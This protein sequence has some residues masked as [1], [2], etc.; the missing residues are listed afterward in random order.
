M[1]SAGSALSIAQ[2]ISAKETEKQA[3]NLLVKIALRRLDYMKA[4]EYHARL[5]AVKDSLLNEASIKSLQELTAKY[6]SERKESKIALLEKDKLL[7]ELERTK[8]ADK[9]RAGA[10]EADRNRRKAQY[11]AAERALQSLALAKREAELR[12]RTADGESRRREAEIW[13]NNSALNKELLENQYDLQRALLAILVL[14]A[15][16]SVFAYRRQRA[17]RREERLRAES[18]EYKE[19]VAR[20]EA[21]QHEHRIQTEFSRQLLQTQERERSRLAGELH[22]SLGQQLVV[23]RNRALMG[24]EALEDKDRTKHQLKQISEMSM[25][26]LGSVR[27]ISHALRPSELDRLGLTMA[28]IV[29]LQTMAEASQIRINADVDPIDGLFEKQDEISV[30]RIMQEAISNVM[31]HSQAS[32]AR[33]FL[34]S[35][36]SAVLIEISDNGRGFESADILHGSHTSG[37]GFGLYGME[38]RVRLLNGEIRISSSPGM[39]SRIDISLPVAGSASRSPG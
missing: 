25:Q 38:Q 24:L 3:L 12:L 26:M 9:L 33:I 8:L 35:S 29:T 19:K 7:A 15:L 30:F 36:N 1:A 23:I 14:L 17:K 34:R 4:Y 28:I 11:L 6:D 5:S 37:I 39:G 22:D 16:I 32:E 31:K 2:E 18:A 21:V 10:L 13:K 27:E 20:L